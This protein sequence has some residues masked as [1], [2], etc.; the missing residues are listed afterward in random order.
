M[1]EIMIM[2]SHCTANFE[3]LYKMRNSLYIHYPSNVFFL[4]F[5]SFYKFIKYIDSQDEIILKRFLVPVKND[6]KY[7]QF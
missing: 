7:K 3:P 6:Y 2:A 5:S 4:H 1:T